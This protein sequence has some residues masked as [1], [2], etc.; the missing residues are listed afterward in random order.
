M[1]LNIRLD[2]ESTVHLYEQIYEYIRDEIRRGEL[3]GG[4]KLPSTRALASFL[5]ISRSTA[6]LAYEQLALEGYIRM[7]K[8]SGAYVCDVTSFTDAGEQKDFGG[9]GKDADEDPVARSSLG[10]EGQNED[11][12]SD[13]DVIDFSP[14]KIDMSLFPYATW[15]RILRGLMAYGRADMFTRG[16][17]QGDLTLRETIAHYL[18]RSR[19]VLCTPDQIIIGA[20]NDYLLMLLKYILGDDRCVAMESPTY[21]R[22]H[23]IFKA[24]EY[25]VVPVASDESGMMATALAA[26]DCD[27]AYVM[28][29]HQYPTGVL[30]SYPRRVEL[31][32]WAQARQDGKKR[33]IIEDDYDAEFKYRGKPVFA[34][35]SMDRGGNVIFIGTFSKSIAPAIR[36]SFLVLPKELLDVYHARCGF[37][38]STVSRI[39]QSVLDEFIR[40]GYF[41]RHL[42]RMRNC[43]RGKHE[44][45]LQAL[46]PFRDRFEVGGEGGGLHLTL[47]VKGAD[48]VSEEDCLRTE[49]DLTKKARDAGVIVYPLHA[50]M[51]PGTG[52][53]VGQ[54]R[55]PAVLL[56]YA[57]LREDQ[58]KE[59]V[60]K[61]WDAWE[62]K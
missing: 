42:N 14:R 35:Q 21:L 20:G 27:V 41:E 10:H 54:K 18:H 48:D 3:L 12:D 49:Q 24:L 45:M 40:D 6:Q 60:H 47:T 34:L 16:L 62:K 23:D 56:G 31:L 13:V 7:K 61:L 36:V 4:E 28:P 25:R 1:D 59:G 57:A 50:Q 8:N 5:H 2:L 53:P 9:I 55:A 17:P 51:L 33:Y 58:I 30:M 32:Q 22:A 19:G 38:S 46:Q 11:C 43:Y 44:C 29:A 15:R 26:S 39:D 37:L 52:I